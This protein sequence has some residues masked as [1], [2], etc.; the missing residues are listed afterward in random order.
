MLD[1]LKRRTKPPKEEPPATTSQ[2][3][4]RLCDQCNRPQIIH[5]TL[6]SR[7]T[8]QGE[9]HLCHPCAE[10]LFTDYWASPSSTANL[11]DDYAEV[12]IEIDR[13]VISEVHDQQAIFFR[14]SA[15]NRAFC[16]VCGIFE[17]TAIDG[18]LKAMPSPRPLTYDAWLAT[19]LACGAQVK[20]A[21]FNDLQE[22]I[23][24]AGLRLMQA[25]QLI[26]VDMRPS[27][28]VHMALKAGVPILIKEQ[29]LAKVSGVKKDLF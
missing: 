9:K 23:Y 25:G 17:A 6:M 21:C 19:L 24:D 18:T 16:F 29:L 15:G 8:L 7:G 1:W 5:I 12:Q 22:Q 3:P 28:A 10:T 20:A 14:E 26:E 2:K 11:I 13:L 4:V 27:D